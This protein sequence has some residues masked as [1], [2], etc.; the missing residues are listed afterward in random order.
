MEEKEAGKLGRYH[1]EGPAALPDAVCV[2]HVEDAAED[3]RVCKKEGTELKG[4]GTL[5]CWTPGL[6]SSEEPEPKGRNV[7]PFLIPHPK[8]PPQGPRAKSGDKL[9]LK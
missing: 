7:R 3:P 6:S 8:V 2:E 5:L 4:M 1:I 9:D